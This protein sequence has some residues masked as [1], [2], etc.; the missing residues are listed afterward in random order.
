MSRPVTVQSG[1]KAG[2]GLTLHLQKNQTRLEDM[3]ASMTSFEKSAQESNDNIKI[4]TAALQNSQE[5][6]VCLRSDPL[7][8][9]R[10][11]TV[12][13]SQPLV[14]FSRINEA[15]ILHHPLEG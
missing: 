10:K 5:D 13:T 12:F 15:A 9:Q 1:E 2:P 6:A 7:R 14:S 8:R 4:S 11:P 3:L